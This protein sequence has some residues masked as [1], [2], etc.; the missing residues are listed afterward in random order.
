MVKTHCYF[1]DSIF[2]LL[3]IEDS[4]LVG[5]RDGMIAEVTEECCFL[6]KED[7]PVLDVGFSVV[8]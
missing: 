4:L 6:I 7:G 5:C 1:N 3:P 8:Y 2:S